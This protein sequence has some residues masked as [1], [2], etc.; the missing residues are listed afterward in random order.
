MAT[1]LNAMV[2]KM[3]RQAFW[4]RGFGEP[5]LVSQWPSV[6][7]AE[8]AGRTAPLKIV[9]PRRER[10]RGT[11]HVRVEGPFAVELQHMAPLIVERLNAYYGYAALAGLALHQAPVAAR[12][13]I[14]EV[15]DQGSGPAARSRG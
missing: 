9:F 12:A 10:T 11:L 6:V 5:A 14:V 4:R 15:E 7:G 2:P 13:P 8:L 3:V 1:A